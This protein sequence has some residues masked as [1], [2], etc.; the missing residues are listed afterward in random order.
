MQKFKDV[1]GVGRQQR[2]VTCNAEGR[3]KTQTS[4]YCG[5]C[6]ITAN[7]ETDRKPTRH[8]YCL[9]ANFQCFSRHI[10]AC[11]M[12]MKKTGTIAQRA[13]LRHNKAGGS[14]ANGIAQA[15]IPIAGRVILSGVP[16]RRKS[17]RTPPRTRT[18]NRKSI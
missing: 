7:K 3:M 16:K 8:A 14:M 4:V 11:Y 5:L 17:K 12:H 6:T 18:V 15:N 9:D 1:D 2:C 13:E 10:A